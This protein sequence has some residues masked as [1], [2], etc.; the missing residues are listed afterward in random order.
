MAEQYAFLFHQAYPG[1]VRWLD[2]AGGDTP[3]TTAGVLARYAAGLCEV[4]RDRFDTKL[5]GLRTDEVIS[6]FCALVT[7]AEEDV[8]I[9]VENVPPGLDV[10]VLDQLVVR[11]RAGAH[12]ADHAIGR[13]GLAGSDGGFGGLT[14]FEV[15][16]WFRA[17]WGRL[18]DDDRAAVHAVARKVEGHPSD[19]STVIRK[20][21]AARAPAPAPAPNW[22]SG[23]T[24]CRPT[25]T[26]SS[27]GRWPPVAP[28]PLWCSPSPR[29]LRR[30]RSPPVS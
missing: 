7:A 14:E 10:A 3:A 23:W 18:G 29:H 6:V 2:L 4:S 28:T 16:E 21:S 5:D 1:G 20:L 12:A 17:E 30:R 22:P 24:D 27:P 19:V 26:P 8:L 15:E 11:S 13:A 9:V 25:G